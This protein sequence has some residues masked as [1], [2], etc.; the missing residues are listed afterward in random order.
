MQNDAKRTLIIT[1]T[2]V[3]GY[4]FESALRELSNKYQHGMVYMIFKDL[5]DLDESSLSIGRVNTILGILC[6]TS[7]LTGV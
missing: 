1:K 5:C 3:H 7:P 4:S 6:M 2:L